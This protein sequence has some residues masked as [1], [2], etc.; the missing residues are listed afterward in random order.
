MLGLV[1]TLIFAV[2]EIL[3]VSYIS[4]GLTV[5]YNGLAKSWGFDNDYMSFWDVVRVQLL[6][7]TAV[8]TGVV[9]LAL[10]VDFVSCSARSRGF[11]SGR[12]LEGR[13]PCIGV[14]VMR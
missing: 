9:V 11:S 2:A 7:G 12:F 5:S 1:N 14:C 4:K 3:S 8:T 6:I 10:V 13:L